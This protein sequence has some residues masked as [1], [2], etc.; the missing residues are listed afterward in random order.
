MRKIFYGTAITAGVLLVLVLVGHKPYLATA[1]HFKA[2]DAVDVRALEATIAK[3]ALP[4][5]DI[6]PEAYQ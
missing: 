4:Q 5:Q 1:A 3:K 2:N 6:P